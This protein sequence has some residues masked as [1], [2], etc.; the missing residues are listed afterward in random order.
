M[1]PVRPIASDQSR[2]LTV[3]GVCSHLSCIDG[4]LAVQPSSHRGTVMEI[5]LGNG[6][7]VEGLEGRLSLFSL[8][9]LRR[10]PFPPRA[11]LFSLCKKRSDP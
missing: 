3:G 5:S 1:M 6:M 8:N 2:R 4:R 11:A 7:D 10:L 9:N